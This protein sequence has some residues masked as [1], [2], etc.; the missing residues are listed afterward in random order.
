ML[1]GG[2][3][4][5]DYIHMADVVDTF[6]REEHLEAMGTYEPSFYIYCVHDLKGSMRKCCSKNDSVRMKM[7]QHVV[8]LTRNLVD[9]DTSSSFDS[10][11]SLPSRSAAPSVTSGIP[12]RSS[13][14]S[15]S[16]STSELPPT[17]DSLVYVKNIRAS[18][19]GSM[20]LSMVMQ[21]VVA[22]GVGKFA[23]ANAAFTILKA[24]FDRHPF[25]TILGKYSYLLTAWSCFVCG[26]VVRAGA[27]VNY[28]LEYAL[29]CNQLVLYRWASEL[30]LLTMIMCGEWEAEALIRVLDTQILAMKNVTCRDKMSPCS[31][32]ALA[33]A[34]ALDC[35][36]KSW[37]QALPLARFAAQKLARKPGSTLVSGIF[38]FLAGYT[39]ALLMQ[40]D[41][42]KMNCLQDSAKSKYRDKS[43]RM[44]SNCQLV[45][46]TALQALSNIATVNHQPCIML[47]CDALSLKSIGVTKKIDP[48]SEE[49]D[50][51]LTASLKV[52]E[53]SGLVYMFP[54]FT[55]GL[56]FLQIEQLHYIKKRGPNF[57]SPINVLA[58]ESAVMESF[59]QLKC[60]PTVF[61][62]FPGS[63]S[64]LSYL[65]TK[66]VSVKFSKGGSPLPAIFPPDD[67][68]HG[69]DDIAPPDLKRAANS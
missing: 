20:D 16:L 59:A 66:V 42:V 65:I 44:F 30:G 22:C 8:Q 29:A 58:L 51:T 5:E 18:T 61:T 43:P 37:E 12:A 46:D 1:F 48:R 53:P 13:L 49:F 25:L 45:V 67:D 26:K 3:K 52:N 50:P 68:T 60:V 40:N 41:N 14:L 39:A 31:C 64:V 7:L 24:H 17:M 56:A 47:L 19:E 11:S 32:A 28:L 55:F 38:L 10:S 23:V 21:I 2:E 4:K 6:I 35:K 9:A 54:E 63:D 34:L 69:A 36:E 27:L 57:P 62:K 15:M 33:L